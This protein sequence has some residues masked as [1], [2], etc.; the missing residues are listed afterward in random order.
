MK[1]IENDDDMEA[2]S[3][4]TVAGVPIEN[5][6]LPQTSMDTPLDDEAPDA[7]EGVQIAESL[8]DPELD[9]LYEGSFV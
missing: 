7:D 3:G 5:V 9:V 8:N 6:S 2:S 4:A 1:A